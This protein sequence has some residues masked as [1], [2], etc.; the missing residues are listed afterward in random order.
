MLLQL[1]FLYAVSACTDPESYYASIH[2]SY[3]GQ[4]LQLALH[5]IISSNVTVLLNE[6]TAEALKVLYQDEE[7]QDLVTLFYTGLS[8]EKDEYDSSWNREHLWPQ[9]HLLS[10]VHDGSRTDLFHLRPADSQ[11]NRIRD[12]LPFGDLTTGT[13]A[14]LHY[15]PEER[16]RG[17]IARALF[18]VATRFG[19]SKRSFSGLSLLESPNRAGQMGILSILLRW[20]REYP[21]SESEKELNQKICQDYQGNRNPFIDDLTLADQIWGSDT[22]IAKIDIER[23]KNSQSINPFQWS[24]IQSRKMKHPNRKRTK[25]RSMNGREPQGKAVRSR[26]YYGCEVRGSIRNRYCWPRARCFYNADTE[27]CD[28]LKK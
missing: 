26:D 7:N 24:T 6:E 28:S 10:T 27:Q 5:A 13:P 21:V 9:S 17:E 20:N 2:P 1:L 8:R 12:N 16:T 23:Y 11:L 19:F 15:I 18:Y 3:Q 14:I 22:R 25:N 4:Q